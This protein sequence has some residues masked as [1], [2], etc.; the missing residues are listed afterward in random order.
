MT[1]AF[2]SA[3][4]V[5]TQPLPLK[6][7]YKKTAAFMDLGGATLQ[8]LAYLMVFSLTTG[9]MSGY[10]RSIDSG[11]VYLPG[12]VVAL[13]GAIVALKSGQM[14]MQKAAALFRHYTFE[15]DLIYV[16]LRGTYTAAQIGIGDGRGGE[17]YGSR[18]TMLADTNLTFLA[19]RI[20]TEA[21]GLKPE[22]DRFIVSATCPQEF[23]DKMYQF[24]QNLTN[25]KDSS[26]SLPTVNLMDEGLQ[27]TVEANAQIAAGKAA[28]STKAKM[29][30]REQLRAN[31][32]GD[33]SRLNDSQAVG[34]ITEGEEDT[35][36]CPWCAE[37]IKKKAQ[38]CRYCQR[39][40]NNGEVGI[41][42][43]E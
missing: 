3:I 26:D 15:S 37:R 34:Q 29:V 24:H 32:P 14:F 8:L 30:V 40:V 6:Q 28:A 27:Q 31:R 19:S 35:M 21:N 9:Q 16:Q 42:E 43:T 17:I 39:N 10:S 5:E 7:N 18:V 33:V 23:K 36:D 25:Y 2:E 22:S 41:S 11:L 38:I 1:N 12:L 13:I 4:M 20:I